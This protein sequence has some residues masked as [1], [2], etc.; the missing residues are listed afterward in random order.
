MSPSIK[1]EMV[2]KVAD[3]ISVPLG[4]LNRANAIV[5]SNIEGDRHVLDACQVVLFSLSNKWVIRPI[6]DI[7]LEASCKRILLSVVL[8]SFGLPIPGVCIGR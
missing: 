2:L 6:I 7:L 3:L 1:D 5:A 4:A 8:L